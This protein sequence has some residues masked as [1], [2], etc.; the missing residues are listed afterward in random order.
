MAHDYI[1]RLF[2]DFLA[3]R[4]YKFSARSRAAFDSEF[5]RIEVLVAIPL[6]E[7]LRLFSLVADELDRYYN[8][9]SGSKPSQTIILHENEVPDAAQRVSQ[10]FQQTGF[11]GFSP[12]AQAVIRDSCPWC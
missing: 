12:V 7:R 9:P 3:S 6:D 8:I 5:T 2:E 1:F 11:Q 10:L 4:G